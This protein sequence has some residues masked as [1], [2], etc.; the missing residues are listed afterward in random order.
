MPIDIACPQCQKMLRVPDAAAGKK[1]RCPACQ[2]I[3][4]VPIAA[5]E[6]VEESPFGTHA[7]DAANPYR[8]PAAFPPD[9]GQPKSPGDDAVLRLLV[10]VGRSLWAIAAGYLGLI[11]VLFC[12]APFAVL[13]S[14][15]AIWDLRR[16]PEKHGWGRAIFGLV[17]GLLGLIGLMFAIVLSASKR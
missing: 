5:V 16:H 12:P 3:V 8:P 10:P 7:A 13:V 15:T 9:P 1:A 14:L 17:M 2:T 6:V 4:D 11:S